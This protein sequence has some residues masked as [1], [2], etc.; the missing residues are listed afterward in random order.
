[1]HSLTLIIPG[2]LG[3][4]ARYAAEFVPDLPA[5]ELL[6]ARATRSNAASGSICRLLSAEMGIEL[7]PGQDVPVAAIT[8][9]IDDQSN[10]E[11][12]WLRADPVHLSPDR[13]GLVLMDSFVLGLSQHD[14]LAVAAEVN[15][16]VANQGWRVEVPYED[17]WYIRLDEPLSLRT[18]ELAD[19]VG[20][21]IA[22][23]LPEGEDAGWILTLLN[24][25]QMQLFNADINHHREANGELPVN[26]VWFWGMGS[27][28]TMPGQNWSMVFGD[29]V[30][31]RSLARMSATPC[32]PLPQHALAMQEICTDDADV[33]AVLQHCQAPA[34]YQNLHLWQQALLL[35]EGA[36][37]ETLLEWLQS[38]KL[39]TLRIITDAQEFR[40]NSLSLKKFWRKPVAIGHYKIRP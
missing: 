30:F 11:G 25:I 2:L 36:W 35:L 6:L 40:I 37:F 31:T 29:D 33:L 21:D 15:R 14:A 38:G 10:R 19:V 34:Q 18:T 28:A 3:P 4:D 39:G 22:P 1:M 32:E 7:A 13:D 9:E 27:V 20:Q 26:S 24:E 12:Y 5:L 23:Y 16:V 8:R 17:R